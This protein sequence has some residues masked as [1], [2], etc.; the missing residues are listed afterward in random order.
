MSLTAK[1]FKQQARRFHLVANEKVLPELN[2]VLNFL[3]NK[4][5][6][7]ILCRKGLNK[8]KAEHAH[9]YICFDRPV[10]LSSKNT[11][12]CH[13]AKCRG[14]SEDNVRYIKSHHPTEVC[15]KGTMP[16]DDGDGNK[17][18]WKQFIEGIHSGHVDRDS[19]LYALYEGYA[20]RRLNELRIEN[21]EDYPGNL[22]DKN[23]WIYGP[24]GTG[25]STSARFCRRCDIYPKP[26]SKWWD[27]YKGQ[28]V[29]VM[30]DLDPQ[31]ANMLADKIK[32]WTDKFPFVA[33][34]KGSSYLVDPRINFIITSNYSPEECFD[35]KDYT[36]IR[37]RFTVLRY[38]GDGS[39]VEEY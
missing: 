13:I 39:I 15:E 22:K 21:I 28:P 7:Y 38:E 30:D 29:V 35:P 10:R 24:A 11:Y 6:V 34:I 19:K 3:T 5:Y 32:V 4:P 8:R 17:P 31:R 20:N 16:L 2:K 37:R 9:I 23:C 12:G 33:D 14:T 26:V 1:E 27:G 25:K 36:A 18:G